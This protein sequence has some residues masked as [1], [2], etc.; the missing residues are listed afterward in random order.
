[1]TADRL[2]PVVVLDSL[3]S[4][5]AGETMPVPAPTTTVVEGAGTLRAVVVGAGT[6]VD[7]TVE[8]GIVVD[9]VVGGRTVAGTVA[10]GRAVVDTDTSGRTVAGTVGTAA[11]MGLSAVSS[12]DVAAPV[13]VVSTRIGSS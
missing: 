12:T 9:T 1:M 3:P 5:G 10:S 8:S 11:W 13:I 6:L 7:R 2:A 4:V